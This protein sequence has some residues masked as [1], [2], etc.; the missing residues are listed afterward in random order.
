MIRDPILGQYRA[1]RRDPLRFMLESRRD[2]GDAVPMRFG[3]IK[4]CLLADPARVRHVLQ[5]GAKA[6]SKQTRGLDKLRL[7]LGNGLLTSEGTFWLRQRR[8]MQPAFHKDRI[9]EASLAMKRAALDLAEQWERAADANVELD[10]AKE[11]MALTLRIVCDTLLGADVRGRT[12]DIAGAVN[13]VIHDIN[14][15]TRVF[16]DVPINV[17]TRRNRTLQKSI[18]VLYAIVNQTIAEHRAAL[19]HGE[20]PRD[21]LTLM[22]LAKDEETGACMTDEQ[23]RDEVLTVFL[24][25]HETTANA[26][27]WSFYCLSKNPTID[28]TLAHEL[29][30]LDSDKLDPAQLPY[31]NMVIKEVMRLYPPA[32]MIGRQAE[33]DDIVD[34]FRIA[35]G[36]LVFVSPYVTHRHPDLWEN[37]EGFDPE[38]F[39]PEREAARP[40][41]AYFPFGGGPR[42]CI[43]QGFANVE[44]TTIL[45]ILASRFRLDLATTRDVVPEPLIT[46]R[47]RGP[48]LMRIR[49]RA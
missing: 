11:M 18:D 26:L 5:D 45:A 40:R 35:R 37:P 49:R 7:V 44:A 31:T 2:F 36:T 34:G 24:A 23:L 20:A 15:R 39:T 32:W 28:R 38:R 16:F 46:L 48:L 27:A 42:F 25:G 29:S 30:S 21:L 12:A 8:I 1:L 10:V 9:R 19:A 41:F 33:Q 14:E 4:A 47:P 3:W 43:G 13:T 17:P 22:L 6:Y